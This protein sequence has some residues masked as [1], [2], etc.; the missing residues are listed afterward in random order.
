MR[1]RQ[2]KPG[3]NV[4]SLWENVTDERNEFKLFDIKGKSATCH[5]ASE[6]MNSP[7][8]FY[9]K[10]NIAEDAILFPEDV[11]S[12]NKSTPF[13]EMRNGVTS[14]EAGV[15]PSTIRHL[16]IG[17]E[18]INK[19][20]NPLEALKHASGSDEDS[21]WALPKVWESGLRCV[22]RER[23]LGAQRNLLARTGLLAKFRNF[24]MEERLN[25]TD[26]MQVM[27]RDRSFGK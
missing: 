27:E 1:T 8:L 12:N 6:L 13:R 7:Y 14:I 20:R 25:N 26:P 19:G 2:I 11:S 24:S 5:D 4:T 17:L 23:P 18:A 9:N 15:L 21:I 10:A 22:R 3:E 16:K